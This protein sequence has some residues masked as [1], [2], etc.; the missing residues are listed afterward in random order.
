M[1]KVRLIAAEARKILGLEGE[2]FITA[3]NIWKYVKYFQ[4]FNKSLSIKY[5]HSI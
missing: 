2:D 1:E 4:D 5:T 3:K